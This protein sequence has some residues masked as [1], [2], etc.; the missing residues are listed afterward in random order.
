MSEDWWVM[1]CA[2]HIKII[3][4]YVAYAVYSYL[5]EWGEVAVVRC[6]PYTV[7]S[8]SDRP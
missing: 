6:G 2:S 5:S 3:G 1:S 4:L 7:G 8:R